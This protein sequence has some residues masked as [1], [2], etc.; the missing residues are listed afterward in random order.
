M[1]GHTCDRKGLPAK[2][3][4]ESGD[5]SMTCIYPTCSVW[6]VQ[7]ERAVVGAALTTA[8]PAASRRGSDPPGRRAAARAAPA[9]LR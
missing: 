9:G 3:I 5:E 1:S 2:V 7:V 8:S 4:D 6:G